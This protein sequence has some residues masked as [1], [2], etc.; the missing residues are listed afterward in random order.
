MAYV[1]ETEEKIKEKM[2]KDRKGEFKEAFEGFLEILEVG[3]FIFYDTD[4]DDYIIME[5]DKP[6][7]TW[8]QQ[9][10]K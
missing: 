2:A 1:F 10:L 4:K 9:F 6:I 8:A 7:P 3:N 5:K